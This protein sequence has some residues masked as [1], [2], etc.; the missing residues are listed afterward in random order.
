MKA[1]LLLMLMSLGA[2]AQVK[3][4][5]DFDISKQKQ[6]KLTLSKTHYNRIG[7][8][9]ELEL[10]NGSRYLIDLQTIDSEVREYLKEVAIQDG[11]LKYPRQMN[12][13]LPPI[14]NNGVIGNL[15]LVDLPEN[16]RNQATA[17]YANRIMVETIKDDSAILYKCPNG[18]MD[19]Y[20]RI[21]LS[22][23]GETYA[24]DLGNINLQNSFDFSGQSVAVVGYITNNTTISSGWSMPKKVFKVISLRYLKSNEVEGN[25]QNDVRVINLS[26]NDAQIKEVDEISLDSLARTRR[27]R[28][29]AIIEPVRLPSHNPSVI[30]N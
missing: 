28:Q 24:A 3:T 23:S 27:S 19:C 18:A 14:N 9:A 16:T 2:Y 6:F 21:K 20:N 29:P 13:T 22:E 25:L 5:G 30:N 15:T 26:R 17:K 4:Y 10:A 7:D 11:F 1:L 8:I 12:W